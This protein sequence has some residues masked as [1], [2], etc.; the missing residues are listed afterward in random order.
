[1]IRLIITFFSAEQLSLFLEWWNNLFSD[2]ILIKLTE[3]WIK[4]L[5]LLTGEIWETESCNVITKRNENEILWQV[6]I[7]FPS[8]VLEDGN[9][10]FSSGINFKSPVT[11]NIF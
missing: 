9:V 1:M 6:K 11:K 7:E 3:Y 8:S 5:S 10:I 4:K 2:W